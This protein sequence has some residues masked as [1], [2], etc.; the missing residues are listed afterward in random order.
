M[1]TNETFNNLPV[2]AGKLLRR[3]NKQSTSY[4]TGSCTTLGFDLQ[5]YKIVN[6]GRHYK[7]RTALVA[8]GG[9]ANNLNTFI[10]HVGYIREN[11]SSQLLPIFMLS[12]N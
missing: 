11:E 1:K 7:G 6:G 5:G 9:A 2:F 4:F 3:K 8:W 12:I 10:P